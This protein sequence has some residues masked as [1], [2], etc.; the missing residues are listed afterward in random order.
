MGDTTISRFMCPVQERAKS[1]FA[2]QWDYTYTT[3]S[4][5]E[6]VKKIRNVGYEGMR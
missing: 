5:A 6:E 1:V 2:T 3:W 4:T